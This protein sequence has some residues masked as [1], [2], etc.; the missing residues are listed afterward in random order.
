MLDL[1]KFKVINDTYGHDGGDKVLQCFAATLRQSLRAT[2]IPGRLGGEEFGV[3]LP[4]TTG[5]AATALGER[6]RQAV[7][8]AQCQYQDNILRIT[9]SIGVSEFDSGAPDFATVL[10]KA[11]N[12][13]YLAKTR[14]R[15]QV[16]NSAE[17][18]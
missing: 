3:L 15:N 13:L 8:E 17:P 6:L 12:A 4:N 1:D 7:E 10:L 9:V 5:A 18:S 2:D 16:V 11:D 14:G